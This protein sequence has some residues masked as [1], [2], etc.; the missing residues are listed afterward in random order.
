MII[1]AYYFYQS[2]DLLKEDCVDCK[3][4]LDSGE[5]LGINRD[6]APD[7]MEYEFVWVNHEDINHYGDF[8]I[9][10]ENGRCFVDDVC[11]LRKLLSL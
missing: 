9:L 11:L 1:D 6:D 8:D 5:V 2:E 7:W 3:I 10:W 4:D